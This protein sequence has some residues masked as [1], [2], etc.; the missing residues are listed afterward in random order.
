MDL[1][2]RSKGSVSYKLQNCAACDVD[3]PDEDRPFNYMLNYQGLLKEV[4]DWYWS[5]R[6]AARER[7]GEFNSW[8]ITGEPTSRKGSKK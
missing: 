8:V 6:E 7:F 4:F 2:G 1:T 3:T 5:D